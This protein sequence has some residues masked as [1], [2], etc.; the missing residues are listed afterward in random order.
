MAVCTC[1]D[2]SRSL[3]DQIHVSAKVFYKIALHRVYVH[4]RA[5]LARVFL[6][7]L[8]YMEVTG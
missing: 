5:A 6:N 1:T 2:N 8:L 3:I 4:C 7:L